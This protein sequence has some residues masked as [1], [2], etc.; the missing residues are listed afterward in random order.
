[1]IVKFFSFF[2]VDLEYLAKNNLLVLFNKLGGI[3]GFVKFFFFEVDFTQM[4][5]I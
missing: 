2:E 4:I 1:M 3:A 5:H